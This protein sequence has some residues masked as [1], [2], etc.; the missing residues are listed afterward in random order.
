[1]RRP[2]D[3]DERNG[4]LIHKIRQAC[5]PCEIFGA[6]CVR[7]VRPGAAHGDRA[8]SRF[9]ACAQVKGLCACAPDLASSSERIQS[10]L[11]V[12]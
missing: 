7:T 1:M 3:A 9:L 2:S 8:D 11:N 12:I 6:A 5:V 4:D 10:P